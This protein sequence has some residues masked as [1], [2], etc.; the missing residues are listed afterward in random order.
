VIA[1]KI[2]YSW[3]ESSLV[4]TG[5]K[6]VDLLGALLT[7]GGGGAVSSFKLPSSMHGTVL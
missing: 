3:G 1:L 6:F 5:R 2:V 7:P 4:L